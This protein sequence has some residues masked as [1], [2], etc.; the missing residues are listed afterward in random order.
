MRLRGDSDPQFDSEEDSDAAKRA[1]QESR[2]PKGRRAAAQPATPRK[3][4]WISAVLIAV[5]IVVLA[6]EMI[7]R[8]PKK[9][10]ES[11]LRALE[12][13]DRERL[14]ADVA[15]LA[16]SPAYAAQTQLLQG[17]L[18]LMN[19][20]RNEAVA[21]LTKAEEVPELRGLSR[22]WI[23]AAV[24]RFARD[25]A[26]Y[27]AMAKDFRRAEEM[28]EAVLEDDPD[29][30]SARTLWDNAR[31]QPPPERRFARAIEALDAGDLATME[32]EY[33]LIASREK[34]F[35]QV[36]FF[37]AI[38]LARDKRHREA[39][40]EFRQ[41]QVRDP[42][43]RVRCALLTGESFD[44]LGK[45]DEAEQVFQKALELDEDN[46]TA[47][48]WLAVRFFAVGDHEQAARHLVRLV[49]LDQRDARPH[50]LLGVI[51]RFR[52]D[53]P[54]AVA[55]LRRALDRQPGDE[56]AR[57]VL[58]ELAACQ[59][60]LELYSQALET[61][62]APALDEIESE[63]LAMR[64]FVV[65]SECLLRT[66][67][68]DEAEARLKTVLE[69]EPQRLDAIQVM[70]Q[71]E[72]TRGA[73]DRAVEL[74]TGA[75][76]MYPFEPRARADLAQILAEQG[77]TDQAQK[78]AAA[79]ERLVELRARV[80]PLRKQSEANPQDAEARF[81]L[82]ATL[83]DLGQ[84]DQALVWLNAALAINPAHL[85]AGRLARE[86]ERHVKNPER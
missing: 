6:T 72:R 75:I 64:K 35:P 13:Q 46:V 44:K 45:R 22:T 15:A 50:W 26:T 3:Y 49:Q 63:P 43:L 51:S 29:L 5:A 34:D 71:V 20:E 48:N 23:A 81:Q 84:I 30:K 60:R 41:V 40:E 38:L 74:L 36:R 86:L 67:R 4:L 65:E 66:D 37:K 1:G 18:A 53:Y 57:E 52:E 47:H 31:N 9:R 69:K 54:A 59:T 73:R 33:N 16:K 77:E 61:L 79:A 12:E 80:E 32:Q 7:A 14:R 82:G 2:L 27:E 21:K 56:L 10:Y 76:Q 42:K 70:A 78:Q 83:A 55:H 24:Y 68:V 58:V 39:I 28:W 85:Q 62:Q 11:A 8:S 17:V 25:N 19:G